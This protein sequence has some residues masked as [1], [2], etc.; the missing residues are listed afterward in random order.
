MKCEVCGK[1]SGR[2]TNGLDGHTRCN[3]GFNVVAGTPTTVQA[4]HN[5]L[6]PFTVHPMPALRGT[7]QE[8][9]P[10]VEAR[11]LNPGVP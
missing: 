10:E 2:Y 4:L 7:A 1:N 8:L 11:F 5:D 9:I 6:A 3:A